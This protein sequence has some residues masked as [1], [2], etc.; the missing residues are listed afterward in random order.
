MESL[1]FFLLPEARPRAQF[2]NGVVNG[3]ILE[4]REIGLHRLVTSVDTVVDIFQ[5]NPEGIHQLSLV[6]IGDCFACLR[7]RKARENA[8]QRTDN[9]VVVV[10]NGKAQVPVQLSD[11]R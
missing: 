11:L 2:F 4:I 1:S 7:R 3:R 9:S 5:A 10:V 8:H 6:C